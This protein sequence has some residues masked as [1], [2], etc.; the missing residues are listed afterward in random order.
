M[1]TKIQKAVD[2]FEAG[3]FKHALSIVEKINKTVRKRTYASME[4]QAVSLAALKQHIRAIDVFLLALNYVPN[5]KIKAKVLYD[6][7]AASMCLAKYRDAE[8]YIEQAI[9]LVPASESISWRASLANLYFQQRRYDESEVL[10]AKLLV[11]QQC[12]VKCMHMLLDISI[13]KTSIDKMDYYLRQFEGRI[14]QLDAKDILA[15]YGKIEAYT[16]LDFSRSIEKALKRGADPYTIKVLQASKLFKEGKLKE[17]FEI[18]NSFKEKDLVEIS[19]RK[20]Y[21][22]IKAKILDKRKQYDDAFY[23]FQRMNKLAHQQYISKG[24]SSPEMR[25][26]AKFTSLS[27]SKSPYKS[28]INM[29]FMVGS[30]RSGTT[31]LENILDSQPSVIAF[32]ERPMLDDVKMKMVFDGY[33]YPADLNKISEEYL[34]E[35][36]QHYFESAVKNSEVDSLSEYQVL[37]DKNPINAVRIP[38]IKK[39]FPDAKIILAL[40]HPLDSILSCYMQNFGINQHLADFSDWESCFIRYKASF[41]SYE[42]FKEFIDWDE[43]VIKYENIVND[44]HNE[45]EAILK[46]MGIDSDKEAY[47]NFNKRAKNQ[48]ITTPSGSQVRKGIYKTSSNRWHAYKEHIEPHLHYVEEHIKRMGYILD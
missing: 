47:T 20:R 14:D 8:K 40:R 46:F 17:S 27:L 41:D 23:C 10:A 45:I 7:F 36:R 29:F 39:L 37:L 28:P 3:K 1:A 48:V 24:G 32:P 19:P 35:L 43:Y 34:S 25:N 6:I 38:L 5:D 9:S 12:T 22:E 11:Y 18:L 4:L 15:V 44:F 16:T 33:N 21:L 26:Y 42:G 31:L 30:P 2:Y 13:S